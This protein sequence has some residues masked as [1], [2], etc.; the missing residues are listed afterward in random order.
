[1]AAAILVVEG[2]PTNL[3]GYTPGVR[4]EASFLEV[5]SCAV[6]LTYTDQRT[7]LH[8]VA[9]PLAPEAHIAQLLVR[10]VPRAIDSCLDSADLPCM[11]GGGSGGEG[12]GDVATEA[13][14]AVGTGEA[15]CGL[16]EGESVIRQLLAQLGNLACATD[17]LGMCRTMADHLCA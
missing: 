17:D 3:E 5:T 16:G 12:V 2:D 9:F 7:V 14:V 8:F 11:H 15:A 6:Q 10:V 1:V 4:L 13:T